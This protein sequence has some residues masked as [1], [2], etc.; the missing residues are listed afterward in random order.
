MIRL[1]SRITD[2]SLIVV[3]KPDGIA[4]LERVRYKESNDR[5]KQG[6]RQKRKSDSQP[7]ENRNSQEQTGGKIDIEA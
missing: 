1:E 5:Q 2:P 4:S 6:S 3:P 7:S